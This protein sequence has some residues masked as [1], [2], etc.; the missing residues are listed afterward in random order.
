MVTPASKY[1]DAIQ[2]A[3][4]KAEECLQKAK[5]TMEKCWNKNRKPAIKYSPGDQ[6]LV[7]F[8][9]LPSS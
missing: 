2:T 9:R 8:E 7:S 4:K 5:A 3:R 6:V 1:L